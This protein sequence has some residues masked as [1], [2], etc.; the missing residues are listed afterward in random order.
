MAKRMVKIKFLPD[1]TVKINNAG[2][3]DAERIEREL[4]ELAAVLTGNQKA[5][6]VE[7]HV[8]THGHSHAGTHEHTHTH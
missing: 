6:E 5:Y 3:P 7:Q 4:A 2:N 8:H 1:G